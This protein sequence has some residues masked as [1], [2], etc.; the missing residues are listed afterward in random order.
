MTADD[1]PDA[2]VVRVEVEVPATPEQVWAAIA[3]GPGIACWFVPAE[4]E[5]REGGAITTHHGPYGDS[6]GVVTAWEPPHRFAYE[7]RTWDEP[8][9]PPWATEIL[10]E[11]RAGGTCIVRLASGVFSGGK[12]WGDEIA[13]TESGWRQG[14]ENLRIYLTHFAGQPSTPVVVVGTTDPPQ[15]RAWADLLGAFGLTGVGIGERASTAPDAPPIAGIVER[16]AE[17]ELVLRTYE[18]APGI[19]EAHAHTWGDRV[20]L[21]LRAY[22]YGDAARAAA[23]RTEAAWREW[24]GRRA[25]VLDAGAFAHPE[26]V[27]R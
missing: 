27:H 22:L 8:G 10:V 21:M 11:A 4:V 3:T 25:E 1:N 26:E 23:A 6:P 20:H 12:D 18:P 24:M 7:E 9:A 14:L 19:V 15:D 13:G 5:E 17:G 2:R 16:A